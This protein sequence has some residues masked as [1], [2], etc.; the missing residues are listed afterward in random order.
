M[1]VIPLNVAPRHICGPLFSAFTH[2]EVRTLFK[3]GGYHGV[4]ASQSSHLRSL[5]S[6][7]IFTFF[8][9]HIF[10][11]SIFTSSVFTPVIS[12]ILHFFTL[13]KQNFIFFPLKNPDLQSS[14][15]TGTPPIGVIVCL[16][17]GLLLLLGM[18]P[19]YYVLHSKLW[20]TFPRVGGRMSERM[21]ER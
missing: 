2:K 20:T 4:S 13:K 12:P 9:F 16:L 14:E 10:K 19:W 7:L 18:T 1:G 8:D 17:F 21:S 15:K 3:W 6:H 5:S 11:L